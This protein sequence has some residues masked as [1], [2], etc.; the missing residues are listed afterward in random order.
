MLLR[1]RTRLGPMR[2]CDDAVVAAGGRQGR[3]PPAAAGSSAGRNNK[4]VVA[5]QSGWLVVDHRRNNDACIILLI[6]QEGQRSGCSTCFT[7]G[8]E[9]LS[10]P[11]SLPLASQWASLLLLVVWLLPTV[12]VPLVLRPHERAPQQRVDRLAQRRP[13]AEH[14]PDKLPHQ[15]CTPGGKRRA[16]SGAAPHMAAERRERWA[17]ASRDSCSAP[18]TER[19]ASSSWLASHCDSSCAS[20]SS[21]PTRPS[22]TSCGGAAGRKAAASGAA[23]LTASISEQRVLLGKRCYGEDTRQS[24]HEVGA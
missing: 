12:L 10:P 9:S 2:G 13:L 24:V 8:R 5:A 22:D 18:S 3:R 15:P 17:W 23:V 21:R 7:V 19:P 16:R 14:V 11:A 20:A 6:R 4:E 1:T